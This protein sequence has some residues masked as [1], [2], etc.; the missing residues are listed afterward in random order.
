MSEPAAFLLATVAGFGVLLLVIRPAALPPMR[1]RSR[2]SLMRPATRK[3]VAKGSVAAVISALAVMS[4]FGFGPVALLA[5][6]FGAASVSAASTRIEAQQKRSLRDMWPPLLD[7]V[8]VDLALGEVPL[9]SGLFAA[10]RRLPL[11]LASRFVRAERAWA[12]SVDFSRALTV[13]AKDCNDPFTDVVCES[14]RT[15]AGVPARQVNRRLHAL[16][17]DL[18]TS[19]RY[20]KD[21]EATLAGARFARRFVVI[22]PVVMALV[23]VWVGEGRAAYQ[24]PIGQLVG[25]IA[26]LV[27]LACWWW[28]GRLLQLPQPPRVFAIEGER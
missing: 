9:A 25:A 26:L 6:V 5:S 10:A 2:I 27:M 16:A 8:R 17:T 1:L 28:A 15:I 21:A 12:N 11:P 24:T 18:R 4:V 19:V 13:L 20:A 7:T 23:G 14:L 3:K 22:V